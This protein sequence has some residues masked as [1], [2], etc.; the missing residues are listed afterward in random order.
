MVHVA[1][2]NVPILDL[3]IQRD[4][5]DDVRLREFVENTLRDRLEALPGVQAAMDGSQEILLPNLL[6]ALTFALLLSYT[7]H[8]FS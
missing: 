6:S 8:F 2:D 1:N 7:L 4:G 3:N 5:Y